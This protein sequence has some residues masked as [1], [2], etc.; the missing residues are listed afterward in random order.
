MAPDDA[1]PAP[2]AGMQ[3]FKVAFGGGET[4]AIR[5]GGDGPPD[6]VFLHA[7][8]FNALTYRPILERLG[9]QFR[10]VAIDQRG[11]GGCNLPAEPQLLRDWTDYVDDFLTVGTALWGAAPAPVLAGHSMGASVALMAAA[12]DPGMADRLVLLDPV[13]TASRLHRLALW[14]MPLS[15]RIRRMPIARNAA[16]RRPRFASRAEALASYRGRGAFATWK[17][18][19]LEGY[20]E[21]GFAETASGDVALTC[22]PLWEAATFAT[23]RSDIAAAFARLTCPVLMMCGSL[24]SAVGVSRNRLRALNP[25]L[26][27]ETPP[28]TSHFLPMEVPDLVVERLL[29]ALTDRAS[30][31]PSSTTRK[32][33]PP[34]TTAPMRAGSGHLTPS[35]R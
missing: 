20:V 5:F 3:R 32:A 27:I 1:A 25:G 24:W 28:D 21:D 6:L 10:V 29:Q 2:V 9:A 33:D 35:S 19:F 14:L 30:S 16:R 18:G 8:G 31:L 11:H 4:A 34:A 17:P 22:A 7:T 15:T 26:R 12:R 23:Q 13:M